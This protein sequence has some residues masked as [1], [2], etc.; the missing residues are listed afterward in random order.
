MTGCAGNPAEHWWWK[1]GNFSTSSWS[2][3]RIMPAKFGLG[4][5]SN[6]KPCG[7]H[8]RVSLVR[9]DSTL[10]RIGGDCFN[11]TERMKWNRPMCNYCKM[12]KN[13]CINLFVCVCQGT[14]RLLG[15]WRWLLR[16]NPPC[17]STAHLTEGLAHSALL[18][19]TSFAIEPKFEANGLWHEQWAECFLL[20]VL[21]ELCDC[22]FE[23][24]VIVAP[25][26]ILIRKIQ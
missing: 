1:N 6:Y 17:S 10:E 5:I 9:P 20:R 2:V 24:I 7:K 11:D 26:L 16:H 14:G 3:C 19:A 22:E 15:V 21:R 4:A 12:D 8:V 25:M 18:G 23:L 13:K